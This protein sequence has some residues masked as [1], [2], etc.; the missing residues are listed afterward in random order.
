MPGLSVQKSD[1]AG[2][3]I[4]REIPD[5]AVNVLLQEVEKSPSSVPVIPGV[6]PE[7]V[8][9]VKDALDTMYGIRAFHDVPLKEFISDVCD[10]LREHKE[11]DATDEPKLRERLARLLA[12]EPWIVAAKALVLQNE[13]ERNF[14]SVRILTDARPVFANGVKG[15]PSAMVITHTLKLSYHEGAGGHLSDIYLSFGSNDI[16]ELRDALNRAE[17]KAPSLRTLLEAGNVRIIDPQQ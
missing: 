7:D 13:H 11:L 15:P 14:C 6:S 1:R 3:A 8:E 17:D 12:V 4:L 5:S 9:R 10:S 16:T 2:L